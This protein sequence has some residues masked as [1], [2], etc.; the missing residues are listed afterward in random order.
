MHIG[1]YFGTFNP[2]HNGH[3]AV[4][5]GMYKQ[6][7]FEAVWFVVSPNSP[8][9]EYTM[10]LN[11]Q[12]RIDLVNIAI[13]ELPYCLASDIEFNME[14]PSYTYLTLRKLKETYPDTIFSII[15][16]YSIK[17]KSDTMLVSLIPAYI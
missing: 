3:L 5:E 1:L 9:K 17:I 10:W 14:R 11:E 12:K 7:L 15:I 6:G 8:F 13:K 16:I 2:I 4:A